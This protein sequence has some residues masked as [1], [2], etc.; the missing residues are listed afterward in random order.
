MYIWYIYISNI[1]VYICMKVEMSIAQLCPTLCNPTDSSP[2]GSSVHGILQIRILE[3]VAISFPR[4]SSQHRDQ[5]C[6]SC[7]SRQILYRW[8]TREAFHLQWQSKIGAQ[9]YGVWT[10]E[11]LGHN[12]L[13]QCPVRLPAMILHHLRSRE[14]S[15]CHWREGN[16]QILCCVLE[17]AG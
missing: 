16:E 7:I 12:C 1:Y 13:L 3:W 8:A 17:R 9:K 5:T 6:A 14:I 11:N 4:G 2:T 15:P 10:V